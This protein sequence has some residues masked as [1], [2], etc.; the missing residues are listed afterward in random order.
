MVGVVGK[1]LI[2]L[3]KGWFAKS[4]D[5]Q[6]AFGNPRPQAFKNHKQD[7][8]NNRRRIA[9]GAVCQRHFGNPRPQ[10]FKNHITR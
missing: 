4:L 1:G 7:K 8:A 9:K 6:S 5:C 10:A 2:G 3:P